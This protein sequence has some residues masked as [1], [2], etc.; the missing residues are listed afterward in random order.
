VVEENGFFVVAGVQR[1]VNC[2]WIL[3]PHLSSH[4]LSQISNAMYLCQLG[5][6]DIIID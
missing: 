6:D 1:V 2:T 3:N 4:K 5:K